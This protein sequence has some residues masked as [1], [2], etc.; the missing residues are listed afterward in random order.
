ME[1]DS[2][3]TQLSKYA[4][5]S[6]L[7]KNSLKKSKSESNSS[8]KSSTKSRSARALETSNS[9]PGNSS[10]SVSSPTNSDEEDDF[11]FLDQLVQEHLNMSAD[12]EDQ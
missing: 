11:L 8:Y 5:R 2:N 9:Y 3:S 1:L 7:M 6:P 12:R 10:G 4:L